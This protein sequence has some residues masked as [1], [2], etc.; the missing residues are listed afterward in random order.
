MLFRS[1]TLTAT[2]DA[3]T[4]GSAITYSSDNT[5]VVTVSGNVLTVVGVGSANITAQ[6]ASNTYFNAAANVI[7]AVVVTD[8]S[9]GLNSLNDNKELIINGNNI[10]SSVAGTLQIFA[11]SGKVIVDA[12]VNSGKTVTL[13]T[14]CYIVRLTSDKGVILKKIIL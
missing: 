4:F 13:P 14:G 3:G 7:Q 12:T 2:S 10:I 11:F 1:V 6:Q 9:T 8:T 5:N